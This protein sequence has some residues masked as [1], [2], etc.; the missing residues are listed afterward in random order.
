MKGGPPPTLKGKGGNSGRY[1]TAGGEVAHLTHEGRQERSFKSRATRKEPVVIDL[2]HS[3]KAE[4]FGIFAQA[5]VAIISL[6]W[7]GKREMIVD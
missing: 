6:T 3:R 2:P 1:I 5:E 4:S 7:E